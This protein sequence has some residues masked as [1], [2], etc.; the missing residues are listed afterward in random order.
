MAIKSSV[1]CLSTFLVL[2]LLVLQQQP[3]C[4]ARG[5]RLPLSHF[6]TAVHVSGHAPLPHTKPRY[7]PQDGSTTPETSPSASP[8]PPPPT[9]GLDEA[10]RPL[11]G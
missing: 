3:P 9:S 11:H 1:V 6:P 2:L 8:L 4:V 7:A 5:S 10:P